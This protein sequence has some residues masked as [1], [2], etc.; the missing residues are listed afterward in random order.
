MKNNIILEYESLRNE[1]TQK[2]DLVNSLMTFTLT[3]VVA[4]LT[5]AL[6]K[7]NELL[8]LLPFCII[9]PMYMRIAYYRSAMVKLSAYMIVFLENKLEGINWETKNSCL[10]NNIDK[11]TRKIVLRA[12]YYEG[13]VVSAICYILYFYNHIKG[14]TI[15]ILLIFQLFVPFLLVAWIFI[16]VKHINNIESE[17]QEWIKE[18][19][20]LDEKLQSQEKR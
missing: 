19:Q 12:D 3:T 1:I 20:R 11:K 15:N 5:F 7:K 2:I 6:T 17:K 18:W 8:Y 9:I 14:K 16:I 13:V 4:I 10:M